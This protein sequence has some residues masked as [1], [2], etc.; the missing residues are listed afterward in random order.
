MVPSAKVAPGGDNSCE[1]A[2]FIT[3]A[4]L[5]AE[6]ASYGTREYSSPRSTERPLERALQYSRRDAQVEADQLCILQSRGARLARGSH[7]LALQRKSPGRVA[8][9]TRTV[10]D[11]TITSLP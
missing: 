10:P 5:A 1:L 11:V 2:T 7:C 6:S 8:T 3:S 4:R 9:S